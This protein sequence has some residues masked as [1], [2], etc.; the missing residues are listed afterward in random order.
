MHRLAGTTT[1]HVLRT[2]SCNCGDGQTHRYDFTIECL[3]YLNCL[4]TL[5]V[6]WKPRTLLV[7][8]KH[9]QNGSQSIRTGSTIIHL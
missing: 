6:A 8:E 9:D 4:L 2:F 5:I 7:D 1:L 3:R